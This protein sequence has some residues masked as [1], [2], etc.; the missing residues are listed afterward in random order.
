M[1]TNARTER[2]EPRRTDFLVRMKN[3]ASIMFS[4][5]ASVG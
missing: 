1:R 2:K 3:H 4:H 5:D